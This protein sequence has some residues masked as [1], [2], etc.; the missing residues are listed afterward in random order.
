M[1]RILIVLCTI[2]A[3][4]SLSAQIAFADSCANVSRAA[5]SPT[6]PGPLIKGN[7]VWLPS[8]G[9]PDLP[10][11]WGFAPPGGP[12]SI[13]FQFPGANGNYTNGQTESLLGMSANCPP[14]SNANRQASH[15]IQSGCE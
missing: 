12:D 9:D 1:R 6:G 14:G 2:L 3:S 10:A 4:L 13:A 5:P 15:G 7:W 8:L 11:A